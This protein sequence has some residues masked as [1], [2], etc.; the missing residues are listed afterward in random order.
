MTECFVYWLTDWLTDWLIDCIC[1]CI[2]VCEYMH[3][4]MYARTCIN[5][6]IIISI[7]DYP[8]LY[9]HP[10]SIHTYIH[11]CIPTLHPYFVSN[12]SIFLTK[13]KIK[14]NKIIY[15]SIVKKN[16]LYQSIFI[17]INQS[18][19][20]KNFFIFYFFSQNNRSKTQSIVQVWIKQSQSM[21][22]WMNS[23]IVCMWMNDWLTDW[24]V[25]WLADWLADCMCMCMCENIMERSLYAHTCIDE[26]IEW[27]YEWMNEYLNELL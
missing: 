26:L 7:F 3:T 22:E 23:H 6:R 19:D 15:I 21:N 16:F 25:Y 12:Q 10:S 27:K 1:M 24:L 14:K 18:S 13:I 2:W 11:A 20:Q 17:S 5:E 4:S 9:I 8:N